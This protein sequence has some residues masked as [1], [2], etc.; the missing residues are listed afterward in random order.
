MVTLD[1]LGALKRHGYRLWGHCGA[2]IMCGY[3]AQLDMDRLIEKFGE[4][5]PI[6]NETKIGESLAPCPRCGHKGGTTT[7]HPPARGSWL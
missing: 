7:L 2:G 5:Y 1:T 4:D 3:G 6:L